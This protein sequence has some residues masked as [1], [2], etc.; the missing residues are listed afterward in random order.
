MDMESTSQFDSLETDSEIFAAV[1]QADCGDKV[2]SP[3][4]T[5][6]NTHTHNEG[7]CTKP[8]VGM[9]FETLH[10]AFLFY[11]EYAAIVGFSVR[12]DKTRKSNID[13]SYLFRRFCCSKEGYPRK[14]LEN[15]NNTNG[16][17][18]QV[19]D[20]LV[21]KMESRIQPVLRVGRRAK[22]DMKRRAEVQQRMRV[23][24]NARL[25]VKRTT[26][27]KW[28]IQKF[29]EEHNHECVS[30]DE[31]HLLRSHRSRRAARGLI[32]KHGVDELPSSEERNLNEVP[33]PSVGME[34][35]SPHKA[36]LFYNAYAR[37]LGFIVRKD[38]TRRSNID[39]SLLFRRFCC[40]KEGYRRKNCENDNNDRKQ[41]IGGVVVKVRAR[42]L[43]V[44][45]VGCNA[46]LEV[47]KGTD[48]EAHLLRTHKLV[49]S[50][51][52][53]LTDSMTDASTRPKKGTSEA[54][55][56]E[57]VGSEQ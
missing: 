20:G 2:V 24:C 26:D 31:T 18:M 27:G 48:G 19:K 45:R 11:N 5:V 41:V 44:T 22:L 7:T 50:T 32:D 35:E 52:E 38:K 17:P 8:F 51:Q 28:V 46:R 56:S 36:Y 12:K 53:Q 6:D 47:K 42:I 4:E 30:L 54:G 39:G 21:V 23:G 14:T 49:E 1:A 29:V 10:K 3:P 37:T 55:E 16:K 9:E 43:P 33:K 15:N 57:K 25:D 40:S 34:F 13:G